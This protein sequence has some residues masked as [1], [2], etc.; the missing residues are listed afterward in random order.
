MKYPDELCP[1]CDPPTV[2]AMKII[3]L[4]GKA[5]SGKDSVGEVLEALGFA[6]HSLAGELKQA[7]LDLDPFVTAG[8]RISEIVN[9]IGMDEAKRTYPEVRRLLQVF[10]TEV[11]RERNEDF[12]IDTIDGI[13]E[14]AAPERVVI[15]DVR[16]DNEAAWVHSLG[17]KVIEVIR[18]THEDAGAANGHASESGVSADLVDEQI[19]NDGSLDD[20]QLMVAGLVTSGAW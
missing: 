1:Q 7:V 2:S 6:R 3:G 5:G 17:G 16:F 19:L 20:L 8:V 15:T 18:P 11:I 12:W 9:D 10:G 13:L 14:D 4:T